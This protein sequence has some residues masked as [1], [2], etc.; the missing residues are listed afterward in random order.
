MNLRPNSGKSEEPELSVVP[1]V[2][3]ML[4]LLIFFMLTTSFVHFGRIHVALPQASAQASA[5]KAPIVVTVTRN[6]SFFVDDRALVN[7]RPATLRAALEKI[8]GADRKRTIAVRADKRAATQ[9]IVTVMNV[10]G[11]LGFKQVNIV[12]QRGDGSG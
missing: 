5:A 3:V 11:A 12:T 6:G 2:D 10:A 1:L 7:T 4:M 9:S 8:A